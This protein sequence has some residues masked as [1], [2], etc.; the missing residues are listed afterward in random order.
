ME[1]Q[2][3]KL[4]SL[5]ILRGLAAFYVM[6]G[7]VRWL[8]I[9]PNADFFKTPVSGLDKFLIYLVSIFR[10][11]HEAVFV[12][13]LLSGFVIHLSISKQIVLTGK[14]KFT[15]K[16]YFFKRFRRIYPPF[17]VALTVTFVLDSIA[18]NLEFPSHNHTTIYS[19]INESF[20]FAFSLPSLIGNL[21]FSYPQHAIIWG[22]DGPLWSLK[23]EWWFYMLYPLFL[24]INKW[25]SITSFVVVYAIKLLS[26]AILPVNTLLG[27]VLYFFDLWFIGAIMADIY[28]KRI[29]I[30]I[31]YLIPLVLLFPCC[32][33]RETWLSY[34]P[35][36]TWRYCGNIL[37]GLGIIGIIATCISFDKN[38][39]KMRLAKLLLFLGDI[40][41]SL[42]VI[43]LPFLL[44]FSGWL[45][46]QSPDGSLPFHF[47]YIIPAII[48]CTLMGWLCYQIAERPMIDRNYRFY[49][50]NL[51]KSKSSEQI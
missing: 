2:N 47:W 34:L 29:N 43:H 27:D 20:N 39:V 40:S 7:H 33:F 10:F 32:L 36:N 5:H 38:I 46:Q 35:V 41:F 45:M 9:A 18:L 31:K 1:A 6:V 23:Y 28:T 48:F 19:I 49:Y 24:A 30:N 15:F 13:F 14:L 16:D 26:F 8:L 17:I 21:L 4:E 3:S 51:F 50:K 44:F 11:G 42:Y 12:F 25:N 37:F 22:S